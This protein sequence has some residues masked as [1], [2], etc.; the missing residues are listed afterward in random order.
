MSSA[1]SDSACSGHRPSGR[2]ITVDARLLALGCEQRGKLWHL[3]RALLYP[4]G[5]GQLVQYGLWSCARGCRAGRG[6]PRRPGPRSGRARGAVGLQGS[7]HPRVATPE[8]GRLPAREGADL[9]QKASLCRCPESGE[10]AP[11]AFSDRATG[12]ERGRTGHL[13]QKE[14]GRVV[15]SHPETR[16]CFKFTVV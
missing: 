4:N 14:S 11:V 2:V 13:P 6:R 1:S 3:R 9:R 16:G 10:P 12:E 7:G 8:P 5:V 15:R